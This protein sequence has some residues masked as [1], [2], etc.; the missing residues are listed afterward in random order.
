MQAGAKGTMEVGFYWWS[1]KKERRNLKAFCREPQKLTGEINLVGQSR[2]VLHALVFWEYTESGK[3]RNSRRPQGE[4]QIGDS[5]WDLN[6][7]LPFPGVI[8]FKCKYPDILIK[9]ERQ[10]KGAV[11]HVATLRLMWSQVNSSQGPELGWFIVCGVRKPAMPACDKVQRV[12][13]KWVCLPSHA[14]ICLN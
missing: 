12:G 10:G 13:T 11:L 2:P 7:S 5:I 4:P 6:L 9:K 8:V 1:I 3:W 14:H